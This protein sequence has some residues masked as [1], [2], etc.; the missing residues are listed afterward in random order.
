MSCS[1]KKPDEQG[2]AKLQNVQNAKADELSSEQ[3]DSLSLI[4]HVLFEWTLGM[5]V[6]AEK[7]A[8]F[9]SL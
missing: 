4:L 8:Q 6:C 3:H 9:S 7:V 1:R 5:V 2:I